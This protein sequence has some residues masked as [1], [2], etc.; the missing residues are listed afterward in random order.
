[1]GSFGAICGL[2][3]KRFSVR[4]APFTLPLSPTATL[5]PGQE[6]TGQIDRHFAPLSLL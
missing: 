4:A 1:M 6:H 3:L 2:K 5:P